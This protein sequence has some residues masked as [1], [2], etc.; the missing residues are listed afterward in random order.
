MECEYGR[1]WCCCCCFLWLSR[2]RFYSPKMTS[3]NW[4]NHDTTSCPEQ[5]QKDGQKEKHTLTANMLAVAR[6]SCFDAEQAMSVQRRAHAHTKRNCLDLPNTSRNQTRKRMSKKLFTY[7]PWCAFS[8]LS[9]VV[10][11]AADSFASTETKGEQKE[12]LK[13]SLAAL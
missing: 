10:V 13:S 3:T 1:V 11:V 4:P 6:T 9:I 8:V 2:S 5:K 7:L 12:S